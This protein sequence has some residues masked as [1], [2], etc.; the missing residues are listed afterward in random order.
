MRQS[1]L[2]VPAIRAARIKKAVGRLARAIRRDYMRKSPVIICIL[3][4]S[5]IF[6][7]D[8]IREIKLNVEIDFI[9][10]KSYGASFRSSGN[11]RVTKKLETNLEGK[12]V[13]V[14]EDIIDTGGTLRRLIKILKEKRP[15]SIRLCALVD[16]RKKES[17]PR[18]DY[19]GFR[20]GKAFLV[21]Y[22]LDLNEKYRQLK[23]LYRIETVSPRRKG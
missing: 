9:G 13:I 11:V 22:G 10:L 3:K 14:V 6:C 16:K 1:S 2:L 20:M 19:L 4:G 5:F 17:Q 18:V 15:A 7:A 8:L 12:D 23:G 21:G